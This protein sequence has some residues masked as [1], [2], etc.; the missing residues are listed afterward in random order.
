[1]YIS[2][3]DM[4]FSWSLV[5]K[6]IHIKI[7][8]TDLPFAIYHFRINVLAIYNGNW[9]Q[10]FHEKATRINF[11]FNSFTRAKVTHREKES[12]SKRER[13]CSKFYTG[14]YGE[15]EKSYSFQF[16]LANEARKLS[17]VRATKN[18]FWN[19]L[20]VCAI[21]LATS[22]KRIENSMWFEI[23]CGAWFEGAKTDRRN[24]FFS[25]AH[26]RSAIWNLLHSFFFVSMVGTW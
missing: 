5:L 23:F 20:S 18:G 10:T 1:M 2:I 15:N 26:T 19:S 4:S 14:K 12:L 6:H 13:V 24:I 8:L 11:E 7:G 9:A 22:S 16:F 3:F 25:F 17:R 21:S